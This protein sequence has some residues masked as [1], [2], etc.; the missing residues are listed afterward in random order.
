MSRDAALTDRSAIYAPSPGL[1]DKVCWIED[2]PV[3]R[4][5]DKAKMKPGAP[6]A[7]SAFLSAIMYFS[8]TNFRFVPDNTGKRPTRSGPF[9]SDIVLTATG[10]PPTAPKLAADFKA[11]VSN[12]EHIIAGA[13]ST[14]R[15]KSGAVVPYFWD[16]RIQFRQ[17]PFVVSSAV[18]L[19]HDLTIS[20]IPSQMFRARRLN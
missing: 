3:Y 5:V 18:F 14:G 1:A 19:L 4:V 15:T 11:L 16:K 20:P 17:V 12:L 2:G 7:P 6:R 13:A 10:V 8:H 9:L